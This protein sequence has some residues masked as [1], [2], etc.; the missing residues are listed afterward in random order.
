[1]VLNLHGEIP[2]DAS[3]VSHV[4]LSSSR[5]RLATASFRDAPVSSLYSMPCALSFKPD[6]ALLGSRIH[7]FSMRN[8]NFSST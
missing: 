4:R 6:A 7:A 1:M 8:G 2:S 5:A 3:T